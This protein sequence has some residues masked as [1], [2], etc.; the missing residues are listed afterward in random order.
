MKKAI[1]TSRK[2]NVATL[3]E[4]VE[5]G[6]MISITGEGRFK[7]V[8]N[9]KI[10]KGHKIALKDFNKNENVIKYGAIIGITTKKICEGYHVHTHNI[11][12]RETE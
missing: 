8:A 9:E 11:K 1:I 7:I 10:S 2:D 6:D 4:S 3:L 12:G 5:K